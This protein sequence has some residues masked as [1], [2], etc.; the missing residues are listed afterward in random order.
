[1][2]ETISYGPR[3]VP[4]ARGIDETYRFARQVSTSTRANGEAVARA[5]ETASTPSKTLAVR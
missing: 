3:R 2:G 5:S 1:M 4:E